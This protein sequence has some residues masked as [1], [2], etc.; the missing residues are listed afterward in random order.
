MF[1]HVVLANDGTFDSLGRYLSQTTFV[2]VDLETNGGTPSEGGITEI[3]AVKVCGGEI[4][5]EFQTLVNPGAPIPPFI[6]LLTGINDAMVENAPNIS[7]ALPAFIQWAGECVFVAHNAPFDL[8]FLRGS[9]KILNIAFPGF[10]VLDTLTLARCVLQPDEVQNRKLGTLAAY[11]GSPTEPVHRALADARAT[12]H[13]LHAL[14]ERLGSIGITTLEETLGITSVI[15]PAQRKKR[16]LAA[17]LP[18][19]PGVYAFKDDQD[20]VL[21]I[22]KSRNIRKRAMSYFTK[23][24]TRERMNRMLDLT[25]HITAIPCHTDLEASVR[26]SR[27][28]MQSKPPFNAAGKR[29]EKTIWIRITNEPYP[30][31]SVVRKIT[32][33]A[34]HFGPV[35]SME[36][37]TL[38]VDAITTLIGI[39]TCTTKLGVKK[40]SPSC[41]LGEIGKCVLPCEL[42]ISTDDYKLLIQ[43]LNSAIYG[44]SFIETSLQQKISQLASQE[45][46]EEAAAMRY[47][48]HAWLSASMR[49]HRLTTISSISEITAVAATETGFD[50]HIIRYGALA[51]AGTTTDASHIKSEIAAMKSTAQEFLPPLAPAAANSISEA[52]MIYNWLDS[53]NVMLIETSEPLSQPW[54]NQLGAQD[55][56][57]ELTNA[58][59]KSNAVSAT[60]KWQN[61]VAPK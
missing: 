53:A 6:T 55:I 40:A 29:T 20:R 39:R 15:K 28:I 36:Q 21:Y 42:A 4:I 32:E 19:V 45:R 31:L 10:E 14:F 7:F 44:D 3:G 47:R 23:A 11:F 43:Q 30:R 51:A 25:S 50:I 13:V 41:V 1:P 26:E 61:F 27:I 52:F 48:L 18:Q 58:Q 37:A 54:P 5:S 57:E 59:N 17:D 56:Y 2:V 12:A 9:A 34:L 38:V 35:R 22:G 33:D 60:R 16:T 24:E 46:F 49:F 8:G